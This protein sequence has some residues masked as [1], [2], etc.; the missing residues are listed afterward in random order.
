MPNPNGTAQ[1]LLGRLHSLYLVLTNRKD[2]ST[3]PAPTPTQEMEPGEKTPGGRSENYFIMGLTYALVY[4]KLTGNETEYPRFRKF[5]EDELQK[6]LNEGL[7]GGEQGCNSPHSGMHLGALM[8]VYF[9]AAEFKEER[10]KDLSWKW[11]SGF[12]TFVNLCSDRTG[13]AEIPGFRI[14]VTKPPTC[15]V[16]DAI[17]RETL[18]L[19]QVDL[20]EYAKLVRDRFWLG[21]LIAQDMNENNQLNLRVAFSNSYF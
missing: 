6:E 13:H 20:P 21:A 18:E 16:R 1:V 2:L 12:F 4:Y 9:F 10:L 7:M 11:L 8:L 5:V 19:P 15:P 3:V 17:L 14:S